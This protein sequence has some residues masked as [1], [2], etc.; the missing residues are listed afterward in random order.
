M[1]RLRRSLSLTPKDSAKLCT[2]LYEDTFPGDPPEVGEYPVRGNLELPEHMRRQALSER[3]PHVTHRPISE[4]KP[5]GAPQSSGGL[6][7]THG[8]SNPNTADLTP[9]ATSLEGNR[10][11]SAPFPAD[12]TSTR[13]RAGLRADE[14]ALQGRNR[15][16]RGQPE[17]VA[18]NSE[19]SMDWLTG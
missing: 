7:S 3:V 11:L 16:L 9:R 18:S 13:G 10:Q 1:R 14:F 5:P 4:T 15:Q 2:S 19:M 8:S 17:I 12:T 6:K